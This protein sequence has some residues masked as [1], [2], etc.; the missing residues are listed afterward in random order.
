MG[1]RSVRAAVG[2]LFAALAIP[3]TASTFVRLELPDLVRESDKGIVAGR[4]T[5][6]RSFWNPDRTMIWTEATVFVTE[7]L[8]GGGAAGRTLV[9][10]VP[11]GVVD[12]YR[13]QM[14]GAPAFQRGD[15]M[16]V[17]ATGWPDGSLMVQGYF[18]GVSSIR[19]GP[20]GE[21]VLVGGRADGMPLAELRRAVRAL[22]SGR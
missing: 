17:F 6:L 7:D 9:F 19:L 20:H 13:I 3:A 5:D 22:R 21:E 2:F 14:E 4:V 11:G 1:Q 10:R 12:G 8:T 18:Q 15:E 16:V